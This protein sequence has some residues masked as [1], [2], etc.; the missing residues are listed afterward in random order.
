[1]AH[2]RRA[3]VLLK[4][5]GVRK[6]MATQAMKKAGITKAEMLEDVRDAFSSILAGEDRDYNVALVIAHL[7]LA[8]GV[9]DGVIAE[10]EISVAIGKIG[11]QIS[12]E[13]EKLFCD[14]T[15]AVIAR[16]STQKERLQ[17]LEK[18]IIYC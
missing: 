5:T 14:E 6:R 9:A 7:N 10:S 11:N 2:Y 18:A 17:A 16:L 15:E 3:T 12:R 1:M 13:R 4:R 8:E